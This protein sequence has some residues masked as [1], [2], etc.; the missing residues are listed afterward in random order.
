MAQIDNSRPAAQPEKTPETPGSPSATTTIDGKYL[1]P[2]PPAFGGKIATIG[3]I[4]KQNGYSTSWFGKEHNTPAF[5]YSM[6]G[7]FD[8]GPLPPEAALERW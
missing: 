3:T 5:Q 4:L 8:R 6:A 1:P 2:P 7:P